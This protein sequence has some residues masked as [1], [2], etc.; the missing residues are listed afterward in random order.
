MRRNTFVQTLAATA[1]LTGLTGFTGLAQAQAPVDL[2]FYYPVAVGGPIA[3]TIDGFAEGSDD[4]QAGD[5][6]ATFGHDERVLCRLS[7]VICE[8]IAPEA[9]RLNKGQRT[10]DK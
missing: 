4:A 9:Q 5:N 6:Y 8:A 3:K 7:F 2:Q 1:L 10:Q